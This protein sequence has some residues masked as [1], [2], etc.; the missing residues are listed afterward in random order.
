MTTDKATRTRW[1]RTRAEIKREFEDAKEQ[2]AILVLPA[3]RA[4]FESYYQYWRGVRNAL[5]WVLYNHPPINSAEGWET[6]SE[7]RGNQ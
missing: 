6:W 5:L 7:K 3:N 2:L 1:R 4:D